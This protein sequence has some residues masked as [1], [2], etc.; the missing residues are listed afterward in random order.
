MKRDQQN[1]E[2]LDALLILLVAEGVIERYEAEK[3]RST[4][5]FDEAAALAEGLANRR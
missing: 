3:I 1:Q 5:S 4:R 2:R